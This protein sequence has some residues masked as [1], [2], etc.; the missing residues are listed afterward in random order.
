[1]RSKFRAVVIVD[2][3]FNS[4]DLGVSAVSD[5]PPAIVSDT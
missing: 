4:T 1:M 3:K 5:F 2:E